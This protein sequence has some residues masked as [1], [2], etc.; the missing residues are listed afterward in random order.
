MTIEKEI[1]WRRENDW[2]TGV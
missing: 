2:F 1:I